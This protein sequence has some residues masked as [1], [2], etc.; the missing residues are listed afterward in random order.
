MEI[1]RPGSV[2]VEMIGENRQNLVLDED[3]PEERFPLKRFLL[4][5][6]AILV[7]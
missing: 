1:R 7:S 3:P 5:S 2:I 6:F 4:G